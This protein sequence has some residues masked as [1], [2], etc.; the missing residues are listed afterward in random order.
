MAG[1]NIGGINLSIRVDGRG[2][3]QELSNTQRNLL[4][5]NRTLSDTENE[6]RN[7]TQQIG[8][9]PTAIAAVGAALGAARLAAF[10][11]DAALLAARVESGDCPQQRRSYCWAERNP[12][13]CSRAERQATGYY[14]PGRSSVAHPACPGEHRP[15]PRRGA[16]PR[17]SG[18][19]GHRGCQ[20]LA[21]FR[22]PRSRDPAKRRSAP[23]QP[24]HRHQPEQRLC[25]LC[26]GDGTHDEEPDRIREAAACPERSA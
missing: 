3:R 9:L 20:L 26:S 11:R 22:A 23:P 10:G 24:G 15:E 8:A 6:T 13:W 14:D 19:C 12:A 17:R 21:G 4:R 1:V 2:A 7:L 18:R 5:F 16:Y 25:T